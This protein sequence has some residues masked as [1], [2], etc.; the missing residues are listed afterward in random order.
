MKSITI[1]TDASYCP[2]E[3]RAAYAFWISSDLG[4]IKKSGMLKQC[5]TSG[6][7]ELM[8]LYNAIHY[9]IK[10]GLKCE[11]LYVNTD[12]QAAADLMPDKMKPFSEK[13]IHSILRQIAR[14]LNEYGQPFIFRHVKAHVKVL[15]A[16][17]YVNTWCDKEAKRVLKAYRLEKFK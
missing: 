1:T 2:V 15:K 13:F 12:Y 4:S 6:E 9:F 8:C 14:I 7:A 17:G 3:K 16:R 11:M 10:N 5:K